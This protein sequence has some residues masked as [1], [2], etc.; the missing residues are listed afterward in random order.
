MGDGCC[1]GDGNGATNVG[2][3]V[4]SAYRAHNELLRDKIK[5]RF[6]KTEGPWMDQ[7]ANLLVDLVNTRWEGGRKNDEKERELLEKLGHLLSE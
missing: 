3:W 2:P 4:W 5:A 6:E 7:V 1:D